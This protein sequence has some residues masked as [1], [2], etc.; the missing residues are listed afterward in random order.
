MWKFAAAR[1]TGKSHTRAGLPCQDRFRCVTLFNATHLVAALADGAGSASMSEKG[2][3]I[4]VEATVAHIETAVSGSSPD[5]LNLIRQ[6]AF[7]GREAVFHFAREEGIDPRQLASTLLAVVVTPAG[8]AALQVGDGLIVARDSGNE[9]NWKLWPQRGEFANTTVFLTDNFFAEVVKVK[10]LDADTTDVALMSDGLE[11]LGLHYSSRTVHVPFF[12]AMFR[13]IINAEGDSEIT[14]VSQQLKTLLA[15]DE[16]SNRTDDD[17]SL[18]L[19]TR[20]SDDGSVFS[21]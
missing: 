20:R 4:A 12:Q 16:I 6:A 14:P 13:P 18:I 9:W 10:S 17:V 21:P 5:L 2:A 3:H 19:A 1:A 15:S 11:G 7:S 8:G